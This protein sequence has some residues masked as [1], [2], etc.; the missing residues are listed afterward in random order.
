MLIGYAKGGESYQI[1][2]VKDLVNSNGSQYVVESISYINPEDIRKAVLAKYGEP[3]NKPSSRVY[4]WCD[5]K[6]YHDANAD[7]VILTLEERRI[8]GTRYYLTLSTDKYTTA[9]INYIDRM[10]KGAKNPKF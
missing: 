4:S 8:G 1:Q 2:F 10:D 5:D 9:I 6:A 3:D 7:G